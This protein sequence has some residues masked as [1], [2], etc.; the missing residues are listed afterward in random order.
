MGCSRFARRYSGNRGCFLFLG[1]LRCFS[2]PSSRSPG[3]GFTRRRSRMTGIR[4]PHSGIPGLTSVCDYP[5]LIAACH[6]LP[7]LLMPRH[8]PYTLS[9]LT[10]DFPL[11]SGKLQWIPIRIRLSKSARGAPGSPLRGIPSCAPDPLPRPAGG[12]ERNRTADPLLAKQVLSQLSYIP[13]NPSRSAECRLRNAQQAHIPP[14]EFRNPPCRGGPSWDRT[15]DLTLI[16][17]AL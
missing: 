16:K 7:R 5:G 12:D 6:A 11:C 10:P 4:L 3:Y 2:S 1:V 9:S 14:S 15:R 13:P 17:R 8:P